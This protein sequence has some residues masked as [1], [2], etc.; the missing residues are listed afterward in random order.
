MKRL[1]R[2][3]FVLLETEDE[4]YK[5]GEGNEPKGYTKIE[6]KNDKTLFS[7][8][9]QNLKR[10]DEK[11]ERYRI[12][13][14]KINDVNSPI[15]VDLGPMEAD[16]RGTGEAIFE[17]NSENVKGTKLSID[18][19]DSITI[20]VEKMSNKMEIIAPL[21]GFIHKQRT[22]WK[23]AFG[24]TTNSSTV[25]FKELKKDVAPSSFEKKST[26][27]VEAKEK[28]RVLAEPADS[29]KEDKSIKIDSKEEKSKQDNNVKVS[30]HQTQVTE[31][32]SEEPRS[33]YS[34][35]E[36]S[37]DI[38]KYE[39]TKSQNHSQASHIQY[40]IESTLKLYPKVN[41]FENNLESY[42]WWQI[43]N[44]QQTIHRAYM[45]F[46][47]Y[48]EMMNNPHQYHYTHYYPSDYYRL[49]YMYQHYLFGICYD[50]ERKARYFVYAIP[51]RRIKEE[52]PYLGKTGFVHWKP[53]FESQQ[54][55]LGYWMLHI[56]PTTGLVI[57][58]L[59]KTEL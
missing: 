54:S 41:P 20:L 7:V 59:S 44:N 6:V 21:V 4:G 26:E 36:D 32:I 49:I 46:I 43:Y 3:Y 35:E 17:F 22:N 27:R 14:L 13:L 16:E 45:P 28:E 9:C 10:L 24:K 37:E 38:F 30:E 51:G 34:F 15:K 31:P 42:E 2:R 52:Q 18:D 12:Y 39:Y 58:P 5:L 53:C 56:D 11:K 29:L 19:F 8:H 47:A 48:L 55:G 33:S 40:Y 25:A 50:E 1:Y 57:E 23:S